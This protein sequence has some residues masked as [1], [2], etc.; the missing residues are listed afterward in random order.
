[1]KVLYCLHGLLYAYL[2]YLGFF[3]LELDEQLRGE[4][5]RVGWQ[6]YDGLDLDYPEN[7]Y[8]AIWIGCSIISFFLAR[9]VSESKSSIALSLKGFAA[10][11]LFI[12]CCCIGWMAEFLSKK[13]RSDGYFQQ[14]SKLFCL[15]YF[16]WVRLLYES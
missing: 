15:P 3:Y 9:M 2:L 11:F 16:V 14:A 6:N 8:Y 5:D 12:M 7:T 1:M 13:L 10:F 4:F